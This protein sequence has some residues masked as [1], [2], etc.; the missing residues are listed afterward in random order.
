MYEERAAPACHDTI[1]VGIGFDGSDD[2]R[3]PTQ[4]DVGRDDAYELIFFI[5]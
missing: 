2:I 4:R 5:L 3:Q 1:G